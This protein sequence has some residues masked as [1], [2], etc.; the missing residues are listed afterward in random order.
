MRLRNPLKEKLA[1]GEP[2]FG[3]FVSLPSPPFVQILAGCGFDFLIVD[4]E[5]GP[6]SPETA[7]TMITATAVSSCVPLARVPWNLPWLAK[8]LLDAGALG[9]V[10]PLIRSAEDARRAVAACRYPPSG[11]RGWGPFYAPSRWG[12]DAFAYSG[13]ADE[14]VLA[15]L[16]VEHIE[17]VRAIDAIAAT[18]GIDAAIIAP[19]DLSTSLGK[20][21]AFEDPEFLAAVAEA[22][23]GILAAGIVLGGLAST[24][25]RARDL[26][27]R[28]Y[29]FL[30]LAYDVLL[31]ETAMRRLLAELRG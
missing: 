20:P 17:A 11:E 30:C 4:C 15:I 14:A 26:L 9:I 3:T 2:V 28:G 21:G 23:R 1:R 12:L 6:V 8:P 5:H 31:I 25:E 16:L 22:E 10:F 18:A 24:A 19:Y 13:S 29:R 27:A 7:Q